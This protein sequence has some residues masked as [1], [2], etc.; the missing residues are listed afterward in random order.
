MHP[1]YWLKIKTNCDETFSCIQ[2]SKVMQC[3]DYAM[4]KSKDN[5]LSKPIPATHSK[6]MNAGR[7]VLSICSPKL[8]VTMKD[9]VTMNVL[10]RTKPRAS[11]KGSEA[12]FKDSRGC[13]KVIP[14]N[15]CISYFFDCFPERK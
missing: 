13:K 2:C 5:P 9:S 6:N 12:E 3:T 15:S 7:S 14:C 10:K 8:S 1:R 4:G 11:L